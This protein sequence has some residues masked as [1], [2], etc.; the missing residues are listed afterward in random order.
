MLLL[1][2]ARFSLHHLNF[3]TY[4]R[5]SWRTGVAIDMY[6]R[7]SWHVQASQL[8]CTGVAIDMYRRRNWH[9]QAS[10]LVKAKISQPWKTTLVNSTVLIRGSLPGIYMISTEKRAVH[11]SYCDTITDYHVHHLG[12]LE[13]ATLHFKHSYCKAGYI[14]MNFEGDPK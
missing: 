10:Q 4:R 2:A 14:F 11:I 8:A 9:V 1:Y 7:R 12:Q 13:P 6:R 5:R 3:D